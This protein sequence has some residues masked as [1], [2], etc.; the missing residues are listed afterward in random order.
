MKFTSLLLVGFFICTTSQS[1]AQAIIISPK[2][3]SLFDKL[4]SVA[5]PVKKNGYTLLSQNTE[6]LN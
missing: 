1:K 2:A 6:T 3:D 4:M 5:N